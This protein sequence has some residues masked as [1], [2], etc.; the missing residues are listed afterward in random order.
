MKSQST[1]SSSVPCS[2]KQE[3]V[4]TRTWSWWKSWRKPSPEEDLR[5]CSTKSP[6]KTWMEVENITTGHWIT[7][8]R[9]EQSSTC[10]R[11]P[12]PNK[13]QLCSSCSFWLTWQPL[14]TTWSCTWDPSELPV[15]SWDWEDTRPHQE[16]SRSSWAVPSPTWL[17]TR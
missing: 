10:S 4:S 2:W 3:R 15:T 16:S 9:M 12:N 14:L 7:L 5:S 8:T 1:S 13:T 11:F 17:T 6:S